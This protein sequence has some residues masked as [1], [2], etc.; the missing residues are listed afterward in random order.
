MANGSFFSELRKRK[1]L[2]FAAIYGA[3]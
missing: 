2:Q 1:V 3:V